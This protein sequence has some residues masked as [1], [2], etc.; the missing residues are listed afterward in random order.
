[1]SSMVL[2]KPIEKFNWKFSKLQGL[3]CKFSNIKDE[4]GI[5]CKMGG[6]K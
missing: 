2:V 1:M 5:Y 4:I 3:G 6:L